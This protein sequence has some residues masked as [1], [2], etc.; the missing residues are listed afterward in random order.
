MNYDQVNHPKHYVEQ[1]AKVE[2]IVLLENAPFAL[3]NAL[4]YLIRAG[5][6]G[7]ER[8]DLE[9]AMWYL[10]R[11][12]ES[13]AT[14]EVMHGRHKEFFDNFGCLVCEFLGIGRFPSAAGIFALCRYADNRLEQL[15]EK[16]ISACPAA[17]ALTVKFKK[18]NDAAK[19][20]AAGTE[21]A[22]GLDLYCAEGQILQPG[23]PVKISTGLAFEIPAGYCGVVYS[24]SSS[25][26]KSL[27]LTPLIVDSDYRGEVFVMVVNGGAEPYELQKGDR[28]AQLRIEKVI[29]VHFEEAEELSKT[30]RGSG[31]YGSTGR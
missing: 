2:P 14:S 10:M 23:K 6:K 22:A 26:L 7:D 30:M 20:P 8:E 28:I 19:L 31:G 13:E 25:V 3:G 24:R 17:D 4:K 27:Q 11:A 21:G 5:H 15:D 1:S 29:P 9:K 18:L 16:Q 12:K